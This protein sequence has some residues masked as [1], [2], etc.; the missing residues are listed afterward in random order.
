[1]I[2]IVSMIKQLTVSAADCG[3]SSNVLLRT[4]TRPT[5]FRLRWETANSTGQGLGLT[6][7]AS[8]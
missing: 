4:A 5:K 8:V 1:M 7:P 6:G 3:R 2:D